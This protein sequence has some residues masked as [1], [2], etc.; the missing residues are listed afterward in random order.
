MLRFD[1][2]NLHADLTSTERAP[3][4]LASIF[5]IA[6]VVALIAFLR[7]MPWEEIAAFIGGPTAFLLLL[8]SAMQPAEQA[9]ST[10]P[11]TPEAKAI[12]AVTI[13]AQS[14]GTTSNSMAIIGL[15]ISV[16]ILLFCLRLTFDPSLLRRVKEKLATLGKLVGLRSGDQ[17]A[18]SNGRASSTSRIYYETAIRLS[19]I[20][21]LSDGHVDPLQLSILKRIFNPVSYT[22]LTLPTKRIV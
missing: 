4:S 1:R 19:A 7:G 9:L 14:A 3:I 6:C 16:C 22:H 17:N 13:G 18:Q 10:S 8:Q 2:R 11:A 5:L 15:S 12:E 20:I 21:S